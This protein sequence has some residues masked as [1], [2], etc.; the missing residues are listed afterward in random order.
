MPD[1][2]AVPQPGDEQ[3]AATM[4]SWRYVGLLIAVASLAAWCFLEG[5]YQLQ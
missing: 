3:A 2:P 4:R 1:A 5:I